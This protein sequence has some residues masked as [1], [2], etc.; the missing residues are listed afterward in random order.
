VDFHRFR[1]FVV[2]SVFLLFTTFSFGQQAPTAQTQTIIHPGTSH[3]AGNSGP[4]GPNGFALAASNT[5][6]GFFRFPAEVRQF[7]PMDSGN[8]AYFRDVF[9][10]GE[11]FTD[12]ANDEDSISATI[13]GPGGPVEQ[14]SPFTF[15]ASFN[16]QQNCWVSVGQVLCDASAIDVLWFRSIQCALDGTWTMQ[17][18]Y[19]GAVFSTGTFTVLPQVKEDAIPNKYNQVSYAGAGNEYDSICR[20]VSPDGTLAHDSHI[21]H[22]PLLDTETPWYIK[23]K[24]CYLSDTAMVFGYFGAG[25]DPPGLNNFLKGRTQGYVGAGAVNATVATQFPRSQ[26][27]NVTYRGAGTTANLRQ[28]VCSA[29]PQLMGVKC[30]NRHGVQKATHW[31]LAYGQDKAKTTWLIVDP[32]GGATT[33]LQ[34]KY[35]NN[36]CETRTFQGPE[37]TFT[38]QTGLTVSFHSPGELLIT[39]P[40]GQRLGFDPSTNLSFAEIPGSSYNDVGLE[41]DETET[42]DDTVDPAKSLELVSP[43]IGDYNL[44]ITGTG[45]GTYN[46]EVQAMDVN[47][48]PSQQTFQNVPIAPNQVQQIIIHYDSTP[49]AQIQLAGGFDGGGQRPKDVN[50]FL[51]YGN[52]SSDHTSLPAGTTAFPLL[53]F[54]SAETLPGTF[55]ATL[56]GADV[57]LL[58]HPVAGGHEFVSLLMQSGRNVLALSISGN[59][60][61]RTATDTDRLTFLVP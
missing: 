50:H 26:N 6:E 51:S 58:F 24:G 17:F 59:L 37:F 48:L 2:A 13:M 41:D 55:S 42:P 28:A 46:M 18:L 12:G 25:I 16:G 22:N 52:P 40:A 8:T 49:G 36:F 39:N 27:T 35:N 4:A 61:L 14:F 54:Y 5:F 60:P 44:T 23:G 10:G 34:S 57:T 47:G 29:G 19:N 7:I 56:N 30:V 20:N 38:D 45:T 31:V 3:F 32:N 15:H 1:G 11:T 43:S 9:V 21:C 33:T 53:I